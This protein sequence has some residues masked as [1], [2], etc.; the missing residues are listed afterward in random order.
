[1]LAFTGLVIALGAWV[2]ATSGLTNGFMM[3][4]LL[5]ARAW[6][7]PA[8]RQATRD[9]LYSIEEYQ[10]SDNR[11][12]ADWLRGATDQDASI[13]VYGFTPELYV[14][15]GRRVASRYIYNVP[16]RTPWSS[17]QTR[18]QLLIDL[19]QSKPQAIL[20]ERR[21]FMLGV[22]GL[23]ADS[24]FDMHEFTEFRHLLESQYTRIGNF[25]RLDVYR[26]NH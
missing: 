23:M 3:R 8:D 20:V 5:R 6:T 2:S 10:A 21:D 13:L 24:V 4:S 18:A 1:V 9:Y 26:H 12:A 15:S 25:G 22:T 7:S 14:T 11:H 16:Q 19:K 17:A